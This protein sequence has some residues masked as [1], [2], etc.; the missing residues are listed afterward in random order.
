MTTGSEV[1]LFGSAARGEMDARSDVDAL[2]AG[3]LE[4]ATLD[5]LAYPSDVLSVVQIQL[6]PNLNIWRAMA[7]SFCSTFG[8]RAGPCALKACLDSGR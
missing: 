6:G 5:E 3:H 8:Q 4:D 1:W 2:V 7:H